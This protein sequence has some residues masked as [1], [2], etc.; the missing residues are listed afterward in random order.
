MTRKPLIA[1]TLDAES[2]GGYSKMPWYALRQNYC[3]AI[4]AAGGIPFPVSHHLEL[5]EDYLF[6]ADG[7]VFTGGNFDIDPALYGVNHRHETV[8][9]KQERTMFEWRL[10]QLALKKEKPI[11]GICGGMQLMNVVLGGT[12]I[13][14]IPDE[15]PDCLAH[16][17]PNPRTEPGHDVQVSENTLLYQ[18]VSPVMTQGKIAV[19]TAHHQAIKD[20]ARGCR[21]NAVAPDGVVEGIENA[22]HPFCLGVQWHPEYHITEADKKIFSGFVG[23]ARL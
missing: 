9:L 21:I 2:P 1:I 15:I 8:S 14:H 23:A 3:D 19:N 11:L 10:M 6:M 12:L 18:L 13:Q 22:G 5:V 7:F 20:L 4:L 17:Q 16:E